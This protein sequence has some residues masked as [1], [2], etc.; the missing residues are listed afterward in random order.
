MIIYSDSDGVP[1][2]CDVCPV[3]ANDDSDGDGLCDSDDAYPNCTANF[4]DCAD[5]CGGIIYR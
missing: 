1:D 5:V 2:D 4:Y 3:D